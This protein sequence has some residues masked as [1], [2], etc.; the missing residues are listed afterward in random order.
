MSLDAVLAVIA[1]RWP[2]LR[3]DR[4]TLAADLDRR[5]LAPASA[6]AA[7]VA[8]AGALAAADPAALAIFDRE[9]VPDVRGALVRFG[10]DDDFVAEV[11]Q[12]VRIKLLV[13]DTSAPRIGEYQGTGRLAAWVQI[14]A[15]REALQIQRSTAREV[16]GDE[17]L[18]RLAVTDPEFA[19]SSQVHKAAFAAAFRR[20]MAELGERERTLLRLCFVEGVGTE[21][22]ARLFHVHRVTAFRWLREAREALLETTRACFLATAD[23]PASEVD[24]V[25]RSAANSLSVPW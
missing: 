22:I 16:A 3:I 23:V 1:A 21:S 24:S 5:G 10:R 17:P 25:M 13:G 11:L 6:F 2:Q 4:E 14:V 9:I 8:L 20:A 18:L 19:R 15:I 12:R 7:D